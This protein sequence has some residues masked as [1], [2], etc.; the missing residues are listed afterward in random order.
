VAGEQK[1][2]YFISHALQGPEKRYQWL[3]KAALAVLLTAR[4]L[5]AYFQSYPIVVKTDLQLR[6]V[7]QKPDL[8]GRMVSWSIELSEYDIK[9][10]VRGK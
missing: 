1:I 10:E 7:L 6:Q 2:I 5:R 9:Y 3:E 4:K 8:A